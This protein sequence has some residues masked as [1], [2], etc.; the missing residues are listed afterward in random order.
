MD[1]TKLS[2]RFFGLSNDYKSVKLSH[3]LIIVKVCGNTEKMVRKNVRR[4]YNI[5]LQQQKFWVVYLCTPVS[6]TH[7]DVYKRQA[8]L[9]I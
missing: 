4:C 7:L 2:D 3:K 8:Y 9:E 1:G 6:Y 5:N